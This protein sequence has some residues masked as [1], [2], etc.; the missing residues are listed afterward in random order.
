MKEQ[1]PQRRSLL[2]QASHKVDKPEMGKQSDCNNKN[3]CIDRGNDTLPSQKG[4]QETDGR[5]ENRRHSHDAHDDVTETASNAI[6]RAECDRNSACREPEQHDQEAVANVDR[7]VQSVRPAYL[8]IL[9][10]KAACIN[11][12]GFSMSGEKNDGGQLK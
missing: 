3:C 6:D 10:S 5:H 2:P 8:N 9:Q 12:N 11:K 4:R 7:H 1:N